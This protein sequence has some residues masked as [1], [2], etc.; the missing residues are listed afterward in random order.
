MSISPKRNLSKCQS[1]CPRQNMSRSPSVDKSPLQVSRRSRSISRSP[2]RSVSGS[3]IRSVSRI[4]TRAKKGRSISRS[5]FIAPP[6]RSI[7][8][9]PT[10][11]SPQRNFSRTPPRASSRKSSR[12]SVSRSPVRSSR[13]SVSRSSGRAPSRRSTSRSPVRAPVR[14]HCRSYSRSPVSTG[15]RAR[16]PIADRERSSSRSPSADG[17]PKRIRK[18]RGFS[19]RFSYARRYRSR[20]PDRSPVRPYRLWRS[21]R[22]YRSPPPRGRTP[23]RMYFWAISWNEVLWYSSFGPSIWTDTEAEETG[24]GVLYQGAQSV[25]VVAAIAAV[26]FAIVL[27][28]KHLE[29][30]I[31]LVLRGGG[32]LLAARALQYQGPLLTR[33]HLSRNKMWRRA[34]NQLERLAPWRQL[35]RSVAISGHISTAAITRSHTSASSSQ[36]STSFQQNPNLFSHRSASDSDIILKGKKR[37]EDVMPIATGHEREELEAKLEEAPAIIKSVYDKRIVGCPGGEGEDEHD[38]VWF[39]LEKGKPHECPVCSQYFMLQ[40]VGPGG[41]PDGHGDDHH[42]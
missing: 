2:T 4:P 19:E 17:F 37:V 32:R 27:Q 39:W 33:N 20:S 11:S 36:H 24:L 5:P 25:T 10:T 31:P 1:E 21:P 35:N 40:V 9:S 6:G 26:L 12:K 13:R 23:P 30:R 16:S 28:S 38:V 34:S 42:H 14:N 8:R 29:S 22:R 41:P 18:G 3:P 7:G 15:R